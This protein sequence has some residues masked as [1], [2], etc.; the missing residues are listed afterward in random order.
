MV[1]FLSVLA[2][3]LD[4]STSVVT[5]WVNFGLD[6]DVGN[7]GGAHYTTPKKKTL[8]SFLAATVKHIQDGS[9]HWPL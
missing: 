1:V 4:R 6:P 2:L 7:S 5:C 8:F 9:R 3:L